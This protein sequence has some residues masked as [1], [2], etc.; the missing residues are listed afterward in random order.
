MIY[1]FILFCYNILLFVNS[2]KPKLCVNCK[3]F[4]NNQISG[5][6]F[7]KCS[8]FPIIED[9]DDYLVNGIQKK[10][11][12]D[13]KYCSTI[14]KYNSSSHGLKYCGKDGIHYE[15]KEKNNLEKWLEQIKL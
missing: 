2:T 9:N 4:I 6:N 10:Q 1:I 14:R 7:G 3:F 5:S 15:E 8:L 13:Y 11:K 12:I